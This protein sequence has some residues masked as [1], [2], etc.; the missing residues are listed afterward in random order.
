MFKVKI[1]RNE[2]PREYDDMPRQEVAEILEQ[3]A[4]ELRQGCFSGE[5]YYKGNVIGT[6]GF[7][8]IKEFNMEKINLMINVT[9]EVTK[10]DGY[11]DSDIY[12]QLATY[13]SNQKIKEHIENELNGIEVEVSVS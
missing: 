3:I 9:I 6:Y 7:K 12:M 5:V 8:K 13:A 1:S 10:R 4:K 2:L 11:S